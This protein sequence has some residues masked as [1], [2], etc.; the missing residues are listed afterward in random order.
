MVEKAKE[1]QSLAEFYEML[2]LYLDNIRALVR[3]NRNS[4]KL[5]MKR[6]AAEKSAV[7]LRENKHA[8]CR[9]K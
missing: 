1:V 7:F 5:Y 6:L 4:V 3:N 2:T 8:G 9:A